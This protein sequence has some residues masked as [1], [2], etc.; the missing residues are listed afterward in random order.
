M[1]TNTA[2]INGVDTE[3]LFATI[4]AVRDQRDLAAF[5]FRAT[6]TW[7]SG[8]HSRSTIEGFSGAGGEQQ[9]HRAFTFDVDHPAVLTG[10]D[11]GPTPVELLLVS[12]ASCL[13]AGLANIAAARTITLRSVQAKV[14]GN[15]DLQGILGLSS[16][17]RNGY[18]GIT[19]SFLIDADAPAEKIEQLV[20]QSRARSAVFDVITNQVP[21]SITVATA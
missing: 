4:G 10:A 20:D 13:T 2:L 11:H 16:E 21:V 7:I 17:V 1:T 3:A 19:V 8:T 5:Q 18:S 9:H 12:L 14:E 15:I 6:S